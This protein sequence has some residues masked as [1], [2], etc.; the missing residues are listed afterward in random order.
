MIKMKKIV[1]LTLASVFLLGACGAGAESESEQLT[2]GISQL[3]EH[4]ALDEAREGF[5]DGLEE[6][7]VD[8]EFTYQNAQ[9]DIPNSLSIAEKFVR[10]E[11]D[12]V[13]SIATPAAQTAQQAT[14]GTDIPV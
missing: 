5:I 12:M 9:G 4:P 8:V 11:V 13:Y 10:D 14:H 7:G 1:G 2:I 3:V 6:L